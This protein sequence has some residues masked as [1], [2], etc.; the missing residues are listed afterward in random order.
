[1]VFETL[2]YI[3]PYG[4][5]FFGYLFYNINNLDTIDQWIGV[6]GFLLI[7][8]LGIDALYDNS[9]DELAD[10]LRKGDKNIATPEVNEEVYDMIGTQ[11]FTASIS[12]GVGILLFAMGSDPLGFTPL[13][14]VMLGN[15]VD[16][17]SN[18]GMFEIKAESTVM[19]PL[20][21]KNTSV[22]DDEKN[23]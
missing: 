16:A 8:V 23:D 4:L 11:C 20:L 6:V 12:G 15:L 2:I 7:P 1:M 21:N 13:F 18:R 9:A 14:V 10:A 17:Y 3:V 19:E 5:I 22:K